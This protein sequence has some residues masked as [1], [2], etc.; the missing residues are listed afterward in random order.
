MGIKMLCC[1]NGVVFKLGF[2]HKLLLLKLLDSK[3]FF[4][5][6]KSLMVRGRNGSLLR[7]LVSGLAQLRT[8]AVYKKKGVFLRGSIGQLKLTSKKSKF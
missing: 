6:R 1:E 4:I 7:D 3:F 5:T 2:S 8:T